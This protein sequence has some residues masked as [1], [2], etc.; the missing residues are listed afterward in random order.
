MSSRSKR[1]TPP[2]Q[3][4]ADGWDAW[5]IGVREFAATLSIPPEHEPL[6]A[7]ALTHRSLADNAPEGDN[8]RLELLGD[9]VVALVVLDHLHHTF[10]ERAEGELTKLKARYV[11]R[12]SLAIAARSLRLGEFLALEPSEAAAGGRERAGTLANTF[13]AVLGALYLARGLEAA[14]ELVNRELLARIDV[15]EVWDHKSRLQEWYQ[16]LSPPVTPSYRLVETA[17]AV[18]APVFRCAVYVND[19]LLGEGEGATKKDAEQA[20]ARVALAQLPPRT[21]LIVP[22]A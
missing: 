21:C 6:V 4:P 19:E 20:A 22:D 11:S 5:R 13:E 12:P 14:R 3:E 15:S 17:G 16:A 9:A 7:R 1:L 18:H 2:A 10:P 8:E